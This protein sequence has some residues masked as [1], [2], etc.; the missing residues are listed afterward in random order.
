MNSFAGKIFQKPI[1][2][3]IAINLLV[4]FFIFREYGLSWDEPYFY[5]YADALGYAYSPR[6]WLSGN[7]DL[8]NSYGPS[9]TDHKTRGPAYL[10][11]AREPVYLLEKFGLDEASAWHLVNFLF[12][13]LGVYF[14]YRTATR[15]M[16]PSAALAASALFAWQPLLWGHAFIN[17]KDPSFL[18]FFL[19]SVC[20]GF[21]M[22]DRWTDKS[23]TAKQRYTSVILPALL[24]GITTS[25][26]ILGPLAG[27]LVGVYAFWV[28]GRK[29][30]QVIPQLVLYAV[31]ALL[32]MF[33]TW[34]YLW[35]A[36]V[37]NFIEVLRF[38]S[39]NPTELPVLYRGEIFPAGS[40]PRSYLPFM[41]FATLTEP[42][43]LLFAAG[44][45]A[46]VWKLVKQRDWNG[47]VSL[48]LLL[49]TTAFLLVY[50]LLRRPAMYDGFRHFMFIIP[51]VFIVAGLAFEF[52]FER[53]TPEWLRA[54]AAFLILLPG[55]AG[56]VQLHPYEYAYYNS[57]VGGTDGVFRKYETEYWLTCYKEAVE[58]LNVQHSEPAKL[59]VHREAYIA[60]YYAGDNFRTLELKGAAKDV[61]PGDF[62]LVSS[63]SNEDQRI[64]KDA[65][66]VIRVTRDNA[67]FCTV[68]QIP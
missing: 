20:L 22:V 65:P 21:E 33:M 59:Y 58:E 23:L 52:V 62:V 31:I 41:L 39:D 53:I 64:F 50:V 7:F 19:G 28:L 46:G 29:F 68:K 49:S 32:I 34:P 25:I 12:F 67:T 36:P 18:T 11:L 24:L 15:W 30:A 38:M 61:Q 13:Q 14:F 56:I 1:L 3:L 27:V 26:R 51:P 54:G 44:L 63:R 4:A 6:E 47:L 37:G 42:V 43:W 5:K 55:M 9:G 57:F 48:S 66:V 16:K 2:L 10:L 45:V 40:L 35:G 60:E 8:E 17:P